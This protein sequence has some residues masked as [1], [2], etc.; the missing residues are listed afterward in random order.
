MDKS[1]KIMFDNN[2]T[3]IKDLNKLLETEVS[4]ILKDDR[5]YYALMAKYNSLSIELDERIDKV[6]NTSRQMWYYS[7]QLNYSTWLSDRNQEYYRKFYMPF[8]YLSSR[9]LDLELCQ[10]VRRCLPESKARCDYYIRS[11]Y[12]MKKEYRE[13]KPWHLHDRFYL[14]DAIK[15]CTA[16]VENTNRFRNHLKS[17]ISFIEHRHIEPL[18]ADINEYNA[19][20]IRKVIQKF[21]D[22]YEITYAKAQAHEMYRKFM[23][24]HKYPYPEITLEYST[25]SRLALRVLFDDYL[26]E[27]T[28]TGRYHDK[29]SSEELKVL[30]HEMQQDNPDDIDE[31][32]YSEID[33]SELEKQ[34]AEKEKHKKSRS[35]ED[36]R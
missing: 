35:D 34:S 31:L 14:Y 16:L 22:R 20:A 24:T 17:L 19:A 3:V 11:L 29:M 15:V 21:S 4:K 12:K 2:I 8:E 27:G 6:L 28:K 1:K 9:T 30:D 23:K 36:E 10:R 7:T 18:L 26:K 25:L 32:D 33:Y 13:T 5:D